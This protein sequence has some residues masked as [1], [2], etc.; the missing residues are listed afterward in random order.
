M[1]SAATS[2]AQRATQ[3]VSA[4]EDDHARVTAWLGQVARR[5]RGLFSALEGR[6]SLAATDV[7][8]IAAEG[9][10]E[11]DAQ[12][13]G[14]AAAAAAQERVSNLRRALGVE[15]ATAAV[16]H[17][18][19][20]RPEEALHVSRVGEGGRH[21][22]LPSLGQGTRLSSRT[23]SRASSRGKRGGVRQEAGRPTSS[24][25]SPLPDLRTG[26]PQPGGW[27]SPRTDEGRALSLEGR[28]AGRRE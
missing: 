19:P 25:G 20:R 5:V 28:A 18:A 2:R 10:G 8:T 9:G 3:Q 14:L 1:L 6:P 26:T 15:G 13:A 12:Q 27:S 17:T 4:L 21:G 23:T 24:Q 16:P 22:S 11:T 7:N